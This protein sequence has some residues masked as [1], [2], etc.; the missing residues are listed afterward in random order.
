MPQNILLF[1]KTANYVLCFN[2][3]NTREKFTGAKIGFI[4]CRRCFSD[5][6]HRMRPYSFPF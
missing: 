6:R 5:V 3:K 1:G 2:E 4:I